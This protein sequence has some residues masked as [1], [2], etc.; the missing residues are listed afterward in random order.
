M[1]TLPIQ[2][3]LR[4]LWFKDCLGLAID[5]KSTQQTYPL[6]SY[7]LWPRTEAWEQLKLELDLRPWLPNEDKVQI[8]NL[9]T[10][11]MNYWRENR[12]I[13]SIESVSKRF[14]DVNFVEIQN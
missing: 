12:K 9:T 14:C 10:E 3:K 5:Q 2:L 8:L 4:I 11:I 6:T 13:K 7:Y 1:T